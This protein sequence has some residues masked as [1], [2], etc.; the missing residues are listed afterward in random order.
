[1]PFIKADKTNRASFPVVMVLKARL[2]MLVGFIPLWPLLDSVYGMEKFIFLNFS[3]LLSKR[4][5]KLVEFGTFGSCSSFLS[6]SKLH[7][8]IFFSWY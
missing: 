5:V 1:M 6:H 2:I 7:S 8:V 3:A 4:R